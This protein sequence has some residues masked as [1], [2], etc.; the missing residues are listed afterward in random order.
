MAQT[1]PIIATFNSLN[2]TDAEQLQQGMKGI[3]QYFEINP[4]AVYTPE[5]L[6]FI[7]I[8]LQHPNSS[9]RVLVLQL[10][11]NSLKTPGAVNQFVSLNPFTLS[12]SEE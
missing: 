12:S 6:P 1:D 3:K 10:L 8:G 2:T 11:L 7:P 5:V 9:V 4:A